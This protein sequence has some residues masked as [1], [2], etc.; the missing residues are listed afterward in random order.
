MLQDAFSNIISQ[1]VSGQGRNGGQWT[2]NY[3]GVDELYY[4]QAF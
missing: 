2:W 4:I 3:N 1:C